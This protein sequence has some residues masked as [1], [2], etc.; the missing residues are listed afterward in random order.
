MS[1]AG[2]PAA[3]AG[4]ENRLTCQ[5]WPVNNSVHNPTRRRLQPRLSETHSRWMWR[6][7]VSVAEI[8]PLRSEGGLHPLQCIRHARKNSETAAPAATTPPQKHLPVRP[9]EAKS[10]ITSFHKGSSNKFQQT[11][12][13]GEKKHF[14]RFYIA[15]P[16]PSLP[17]THPYAEACRRRDN[18]ISF[19][20]LLKNLPTVL[21][22]DPE[23]SRRY[24]IHIIRSPFL[25]PG[26]ARAVLPRRGAKNWGQRRKTSPMQLLLPIMLLKLDVFFLFSFQRNYIWREREREGEREKEKERGGF[27]TEV[28][29]PV[30]G[31]GRHTGWSWKGL[32]GG[33]RQAGES[34]ARVL[35]LREAESEAESR[36]AEVGQS[37]TA[38]P[39]LRAR[40]R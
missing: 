8:S 33:G 31:V 18:N 29:S 7:E 39:K 16:P 11:S 28:W 21:E 24:Q 35:V 25:P 27:G 4:L 30:W 37:G 6:G 38:V 40:D 3:M 14:K 36:R 20:V 23:P 5:H 32:R 1:S 34:V 19:R 17:L 12:R 2:A 22:P 13:R 15:P 10:R 9:K 26:P